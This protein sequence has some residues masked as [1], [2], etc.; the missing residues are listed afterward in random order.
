MMRSFLIAAVSLATLA[1]QDSTPPNWENTVTAG[2]Q[3]LVWDLYGSI[4][5]DQPQVY[6]TQLGP[7]GASWPTSGGR[8]RGELFSGS[9]GVPTGPNPVGRSPRVVVDLT[10]N[11]EWRLARLRAVVPL[12]HSKVRRFRK[13]MDE[14][15]E[16]SDEEALKDLVANGARYGPA[17]SLA[18]RERLTESLRKFMGDIHIRSAEFRLRFHQDG[19]GGVKYVPEGYWILKVEGRRALSTW[20]Y[21]VQLEP[22]DGLIEDISLVDSKP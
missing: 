1:P 18:V 5:A 16:W 3:A 7:V 15:Q 12:Q 14:H 17:A 6:I 19:V 4:V 22:F 9:D 20:N 13:R 2:M 8:F 21:L 10:F 11:E